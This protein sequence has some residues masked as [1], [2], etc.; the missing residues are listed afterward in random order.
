MKKIIFCLILGLSV[1]LG[2]T[3]FAQSSSVR[4][5]PI[6]PGP[7]PMP[8]PI[9]TTTPGFI[10]MNV[11]GQN[12]NGKNPVRLSELSCDVQ[13]FGNIA[14]TT[15]DMT[16]V[17]NSNRVLEGEF[18]FPLGQNESVTGYA[19][20][21]NGKMRKGVVVE[22]D[23][24]RQVF[25]AV[26]RQGIDPGLV[27]MTSGNNFKTRVYPLPANGSRH[28]QITYQSEL[29]SVLENGAAGAGD[30]AAKNDSKIYYIYDA[31]CKEELDSFNF[32]VTVLDNAS[33]K[34]KNAEGKGADGKSTVGGKGNKSGSKKNLIGL[35]D[36]NSGYISQFSKKNYR[37]EAPL[38]I[39]LPKVFGSDFQKVFTQNIGKDTYFYFAVDSKA[40][41]RDEAAL[42]PKNL[43][44]KIAVWW[45]VSSSGANRNLQEELNLLQVYVSQ[46]QNPTVIVVPF[47]NQVHEAVQLTGNSKKQLKEL[48]DFING[49]EYDGATNLNY[50][51][52]GL[53][54]ADEVLIFSDG[55]AN[56][57]EEKNQIS[58]SSV[59]FSGVASAG[60]KKNN[61]VINTINSSV[62]ASHSYLQNLA[63]K[64]GGVYINLCTKSA[65][66]G[67]NLLKNE[68]Y[69]LI[70][71]E[72]NPS[73][74]SEVYPQSGEIV[75]SDGIFGVSG[76]LNRKEA[77]ITL[78]FGYGKTVEKSVT[79]EVSAID[80]VPC[81]YV[82]R[83]WAAKK[84]DN[85]SSDY[86]KN[87]T[88]ITELAKNFGI[89]TKDTSLIVLDSVQDYVRY[90]IVPPDELL[91]EYNRLLQNRGTFKPVDGADSGEKGKVPQSVYQ[92]F[93]EFREWWNKKP[94]DFK[95]DKK[96]EGFFGGIRLM[97]SPADYEEA[98]QAFD[99]EDFVELMDADVLR[100]NRMGVTNSLVESRGR[101]DFAS[102]QE[103]SAKG[104]DGASSDEKN[105][106][107]KIQLQAWN[108]DMPYLSELKRTRTEE[109]YARYLELKKEYG[110]SP[111]FYMEV[112]D[113]FAEEGLDWQSMR[114][115]SNLAELNL[116]NTDVLRAL[117][118]KLVE[119]GN[120]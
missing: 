50:D 78:N 67:V 31:L 76:K 42:R 55:I 89:V 105:T 111:A 72:Y 20:D 62:S 102:E 83:Q 6:I 48:A 24:G 21:I 11:P 23:K 81:D 53:V 4:P 5:L 77:K 99:Q 27:E 88:Q 90:G 60:T 56:W 22:K 110:G 45:D 10:K 1:F 16:F 59:G 15:L 103:R 44:K 51:F 37:L 19:L 29:E 34:G 64:N 80:S 98:P 30:A 82:A 106:D 108:P 63:Q 104:V 8:V 107:A 2:Y 66:E 9:P 47:C 119:R 70:S 97:N 86:E 96:K 79:V 46:L 13:V 33:P 84:I 92:T 39:E 95:K 49:L 58:N 14:V 32:K 116:E 93:K 94:G 7:I 69:H 91:D 114:I 12:P 109:M 87:V 38:I 54:A 28:V 101:S 73:L 115:L 61:C 18:E 118:N 52:A 113:Y 100:T 17:N 40:G 41:M 71:A 74:I 75:S 3:L 57:D 35:D 120:F 36:L 85:L 25:E 112:S 68:P 26:V 43:P 117:G 65:D